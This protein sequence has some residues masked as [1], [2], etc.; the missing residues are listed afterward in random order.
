MWNQVW[1]STNLGRSSGTGDAKT[2]LNQMYGITF[3]RLPWVKLRADAHYA[4]FSRSFGNGSY[5]AVLLVTANERST[6]T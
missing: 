1:L 3:G 4:R 2:S 5:E 6:A